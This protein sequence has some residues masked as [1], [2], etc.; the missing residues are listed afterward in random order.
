MPKQPRFLVVVDDLCGSDCEFATF[1][2]A[3]R[4][5]SVIAGV[6]TYGVAEFIQPGYTVLPHSRTPVRMALG[7]SD[8]YGDGRS[9]DG[10]GFDVDVLLPTA[11]S[12]SGEGILA[13]ARRLK[14]QS[15]VVA[16]TDGSLH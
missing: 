3:T 11:E 10:Y 15:S 14:T 4:G 13:L 7:L 2:F 5:E 16:K 9:L 8:F 12:Q 1:V 6:S